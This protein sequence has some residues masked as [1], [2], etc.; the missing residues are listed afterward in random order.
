M[1][2]SFT[3]WKTI[4]QCHKWNIHFKQRLWYKYARLYWI[5]LYWWAHLSQS[6]QINSQH[7]RADSFE[8]C[9]QWPLLMCKSL[10]YYL[11]LLYRN[12]FILL[13]VKC[14]LGLFVFP[15]NPPNSD[16]D[17]RIFNVRTWSF[18]CMWIHTGVGDADSESAQHF[19]VR[20]AHKFVFYCLWSVHNFEIYHKSL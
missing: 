2:I 18:L 7:R 4:H 9:C 15:R 3:N 11:Q 12:T 20:K 17:Y 10:P 16:M 6:L 8:A 19:L 5:Q 13:L 14:M 1:D